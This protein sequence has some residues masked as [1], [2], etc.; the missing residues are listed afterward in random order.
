MSSFYDKNCDVSAMA[1]SIYAACRGAAPENYDEIIHFPMARKVSFLKFSAQILIEI[2][3]KQIPNRNL[4]FAIPN[5][6][7]A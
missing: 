6:N 7:R 4:P 3:R 2:V 1:K 5:R